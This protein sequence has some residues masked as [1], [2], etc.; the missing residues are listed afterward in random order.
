MI[1]SKRNITTS[2]NIKPLDPMAVAA[3]VGLVTG[4]YLPMA[5]N[6]AGWPLTGH[7]LPIIVE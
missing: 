3:C 6:T 4:R 2:D 5:L 7:M 1:K